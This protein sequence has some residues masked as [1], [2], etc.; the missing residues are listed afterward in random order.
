VAI[1]PGRV[2]EGTVSD[3]DTGRP[4]AG[5]RIQDWIGENHQSDAQGRFRLMGQPKG[6]GN[7]PTFLYATVDGQPYIK[8]GK[9]LDEPRGLGAVRLDIT[10]KRG[11][12]A[13]GTVT[14]PATGK[15]AKAVVIYY[16]FRDN[17]NVKDCPD[18]TFL[19]NHIGDE[20][21]F[22]TD[23]NGR[24]RIPVL[25]GGGLLAVRASEPGYLVAEPDEKTAGKALHLGDYRFY[26]RDFHALLPIDAPAGKT[27][28][29]PHIPLA[30][31]RMQH[32]RIVDPDGK[33]VSGAKVLCLQFRSLAGQI[34]PEDE[35]TF[36]HANPGKAESL[37]VW[38]ADRSLGAQIDLKGDEPDPVRL[39]LQPT[40]SV[41]GRLLDEDGKPRPGVQLGI[42][43]RYL[44]R[45]HSN[46]SDRFDPVTTGADGRFQIT[47]LVPGVTYTIQVIKR[48]EM[49]DSLRT[50]GYLHRTEWT[51]KPGESLDWRDV[52]VKPYRP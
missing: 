29:V 23:A 52:Q 4:I 19:N 50:E 24:F 8:Y 15:P 39:V 43:Q 21:E 3:R 40:G 14:S 7:V 17:P 5:A 30:A 49:N 20:P 51:I 16:P 1:A 46:G 25:P 45:G 35:M 22:P 33:P 11:I 32:I 41:A 10:L 26:M 44:S 6:A 9:A 27:L 34:V 28:V 18:A 31:G 38:Q 37:I 47:Q 36:I 48:G 12:W 42:H 13:E 2:I